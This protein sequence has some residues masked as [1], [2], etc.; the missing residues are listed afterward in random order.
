MRCRR[1]IDS[2]MTVSLDLHLRDYNE[3]L[4][5]EP[6]LGAE[7][8]AFFLEDSARDTCETGSVLVRRA[9][10]RGVDF[11]VVAMPTCFPGVLLEGVGMTG[12]VVRRPFGAV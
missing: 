4:T 6:R 1:K 11:A 5:S 10:I 12:L 9:A 8:E 2:E 3:E 7:D